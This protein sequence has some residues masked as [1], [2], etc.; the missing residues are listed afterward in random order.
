MSLGDRIQELRTDKGIL[1]KDLAKLLNVSVATISHYELNV[2]LP[3]VETLK[4]IALYF[5]VSS[6]YLL[7]II[8]EPAPINNDN[9]FIKVPEK[10]SSHAKDEIKS[11]IRYL[12][13]KNNI[14]KSISI[15]EKHNQRLKNKI[16]LDSKSKIKSNEILELILTYTDSKEEA[17]ELASKL[18]NRF[19]SLT[20]VVEAS[21]DELLNVKDISN[22]VVV[23]I[24]T[25]YEVLKIYSQENNFS[26]LN[27][28]LL[29]EDVCKIIRAK[30][31]DN[32]EKFVLILLDSELKIIFMDYVNPYDNK[33]ID[34]VVSK[35]KELDASYVILANNCINDTINF[36]KNDVLF[37]DKLKSELTKSGCQ[38]LDY[39]IFKNNNFVSFYNNILNKGK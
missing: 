5:N 38:F 4:K 27:K 11:F 17:K 29:F 28:T 31:A 6:D 33:L 32:N 22:D 8:N 20:N 9:S 21:V 36:T 14:D 39:I 30:F 15:G 7:G 25:Y 24:K 2:N 34:S 19:G 37:V 3:D 12:E 35:S 18:I 26:S 16:L 1:Q 13:M 10:L 23:L